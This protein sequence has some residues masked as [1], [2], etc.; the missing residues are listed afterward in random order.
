MENNKLKTQIF[1]QKLRKHLPV[2]YFLLKIPPLIKIKSTM[3]CSAFH[4]DKNYLVGTTYKPIS[5]IV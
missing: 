2:N 5:N 1:D 3:T 4:S